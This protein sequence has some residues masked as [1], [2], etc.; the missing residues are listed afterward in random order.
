MIE[1]DYGFTAEFARVY[2]Q[3]VDVPAEVTEELERLDQCED[4]LMSVEANDWTEEFEA[5]ADRLAAR[6]DELQQI[7]QEHVAFSEDDRKRAG[8]IVTIGHDGDVQLH[9]GLI[10]HDAIAREHDGDDDGEPGKNTSD[11]PAEAP[12]SGGQT[13]RQQHS[14]SQGL[15]RKSTRLNSRHSCA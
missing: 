1:P 12:L 3:P 5:E 10:P 13:V 7:V 6:R 8:C 9:E 2:P 14:F 11:T 4:E 15:D